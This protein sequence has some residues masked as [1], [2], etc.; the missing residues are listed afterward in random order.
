MDCSSLFRLDGRIA[1][2]TGGSRGIGRMIAE[3]FLAQGATVYIAARK[4]AACAATAEELGPNCIP[5]PVDVATVEG[6][7]ALAAALAERETR[8]DILVNNA[9]A[10]WGVAF[11]EFPEQGWDKVMDLNVKSPFFL[12]QALHP[13]LTAAGVDRPAKV[14]NISSIDGQRLNPWETYSYHAS[15]AALIYLTKRMAARLVR[16]RINVTSI[17]PGAFASEMNRAARDHGDA[18]AQAIPAGRIGEPEDMAAAAIYLASRAGDYVVGE[19]ITVD[20]GLVHAAL[21]TSIDG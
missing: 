4:A 5:L 8:L 19:T 11:E 2:V 9:G 10:A 14:I 3:G 17:A 16:D 15:K 21:G 12:T 18:V 6:C 1:L 13:L 20:G 7:R